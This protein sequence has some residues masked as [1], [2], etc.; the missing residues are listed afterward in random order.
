MGDRPF[1]AGPGASEDAPSHPVMTIIPRCRTNV[2]KRPV[3]ARLIHA[4]RLPPR[5][6]SS[7]PRGR[8]GPTRRQGRCVSARSTARRIPDEPE[9]SPSA[10]RRRISSRSLG[11]WR[12]RRRRGRRR[13]ARRLRLVRGGETRWEAGARAQERT[14]RWPRGP[15]AARWRWPEPRSVRSCARAGLLRCTP[16]QGQRLRHQRRRTRSARA[17]REASPRGGSPLPGAV[18]ASGRR[19]ATAAASGGRG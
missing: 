15:T 16:E 17:L 6:R 11:R 10:A 13:S 19:E 1:R 18:S 2:T 7:A 4:A 3:G 14:Y 5:G 12:G 8:C 9:R